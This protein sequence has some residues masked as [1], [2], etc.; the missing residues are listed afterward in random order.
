MSNPSDDRHDKT[1]MNIIN[2]GA[3][4][5]LDDNVFDENDDGSQYLHLEGEGEPSHEPEST[6]E[7]LLHKCLQ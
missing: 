5:D 2:E 3:Q 4:F 6:G 1:M 7:V